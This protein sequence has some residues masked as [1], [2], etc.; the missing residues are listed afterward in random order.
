MLVIASTAFAQPNYEFSFA[1]IGDPQLG[2]GATVASGAIALDDLVDKINT[3]IGERT[4]SFS[5][6]VG[7]L[8]HH[9]DSTD[10]YEICKASL[11]G[12]DSLYYW[13]PG[14]HE[15]ASDGGETAY[16]E[17]ESVFG[18]PPP[19]VAGDDSA[20][21]FVKNSWF[22]VGIDTGDRITKRCVP[23]DELQRELEREEHAD[24]FG[25]VFSHYGLWQHP[26][27]MQW[28]TDLIK[29][30]SATN[31]LLHAF[32]S[33][34]LVFSGHRHLNF[35]LMGN[36]NRDGQTIQYVSVPRPTSLSQKAWQY[37]VYDDGSYLR[38]P[39]F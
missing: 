27:G 35:G 5:L 21:S 37:D 10:V 17:L 18:Y 16:A 8:I 32:D 7:D 23:L 28:D 9:A 29:N 38:T 12:L 26:D 24:K 36:L 4:A 15:H 2:F 13:V 34:R 39:I 11:D 6:I 33:V 25:I 14:N 1:V 22:V 30:A 3:G 20:F 19:D 31:D